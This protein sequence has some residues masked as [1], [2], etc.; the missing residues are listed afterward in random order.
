MTCVRLQKH[1]FLAIF[2]QQQLGVPNAGSS[3]L[4]KQGLFERLLSGQS[5][6]LQDAIC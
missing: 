4:L 3:L 2:S 1:L 5:F 6:G